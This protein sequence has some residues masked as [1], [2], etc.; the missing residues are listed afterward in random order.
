MR[1]QFSQES[2]EKRETIFD[3]AYHYKLRAKWH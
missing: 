1:K 3:I 2:V